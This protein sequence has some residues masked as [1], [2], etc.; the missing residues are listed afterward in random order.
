MSDEQLSPEDLQERKELAGLVANSLAKGEKPADISQQLVNSGWEQGAADEFVNRI[1][2]H[3]ASAS[4]NRPA[5]RS[6]DE[7]GSGMGWLVWIGVIL[8]INFLSFVF[9]WGFWIY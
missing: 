6:S 4:A 2:L 1:A 5:A 3:L 8:L 7:G 9:N